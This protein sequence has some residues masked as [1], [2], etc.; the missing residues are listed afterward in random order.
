MS[1]SFILD[2][3]KVE[4]V[5]NRNVVT[6]SPEMPVPALETLFEE[7]H[8]TG[9]PVVKDGKLVGIVTISD[10]QKI[11]PEKRDKLKIRDIASRKLVVTYPDE[12]VHQALD[13]MYVKDVGRLPVVDRRDP[14]K[15]LGIISKHD[16]LKAFE[17][18]ERREAEEASEGA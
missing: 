14:T 10:V 3:I 9:Y 11:P 7:Y 6:L 15:I 1:R 4:E 17:L 8:H 2:S 5:M 16:I 18:A 13:K 12:T